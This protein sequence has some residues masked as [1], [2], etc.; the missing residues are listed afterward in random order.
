MKGMSLL[1]MIR[2]PLFLSCLSAFLIIAPTGIS[3]LY[4]QEGKDSL[5]LSRD[6]ILEM[7]Y[8]SLLD[9]PMEEVLRI[10]RVAGLTVDELFNM[11]ISTAGNKK[12][13]VSEVPASVVVLTR[14]DIAN[15]G[16]R[17][18]S[19][20]L[21]HVPGLYPIDNLSFF[22]TSFGVRGFWADQ[23][24][25]NLMIMID[26]VKQTF[27]F[28]GSHPLTKA[29]IPV[30]SIE[31]IEIIRGPMSVI[32]G[33]GAFFGAINIITKPQKEISDCQASLSYGS[34]NTTQTFL[35]I[36]EYKGDAGFMVNAS[37]TISD[38]MDEPLS[39][40]STHNYAPLGYTTTTDRLGESNKF[41]SLN[42][43]WKG[44]NAQ[45]NYMESRKGGFL[46]QP[47]G[48]EGSISELR[49]TS[50]SLE[51]RKKISQWFTA[52]A[53]LRYQHDW[54]NN[55]LDRDW[56][57]R[58][59]DSSLHIIADIYEYDQYENN[60]VEVEAI[61][62]LNPLRALSITAGL[63]YRGVTELN[64][65]N[66]HPI[67]MNPIYYNADWYLENPA[68]IANL[69]PYLQIQYVPVEKLK[70]IGG[71]RLQYSPGFEFAI[72]YAYDTVA[73]KDPYFTNKYLHYSYHPD[74]FELVPRLAAIYS[75]NDEN[76]LK[77]LYGKAMK[78][79]SFE[80]V[81]DASTRGFDVDPEY[82]NTLEINYTSRISS[83]LKFGASAF[84][85]YLD[86]LIVR[87]TLIEYLPNDTNLYSV[88]DNGAN[89][90]SMGAEL[91]FTYTPLR[92][93]NLQAALTYQKTRSRNPDTDSFPVPYSPPLL[94][95]LNLVWNPIS[96][97]N[98]S[99]SATYVDKMI[100][101]WDP[102]KRAKDKTL[103]AYYGV[104]G[105][106]YFNLGC[107]FRWD[108]ILRTPFY[109]NLHVMN[110][111]N[112]TQYYP[113]TNFSSWADKGTL[114][115]MRSFLFTLGIHF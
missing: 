41:F 32:Y 48:R 110:L 12:E 55:D 80:S 73:F 97:M 4:G 89:R 29:S 68:G 45:M 47:S 79:A 7:P 59:K 82:I 115:P 37:W 70:I 113:T 14:E 85:N 52:E 23:E 36:R 18:V 10:A 38:G 27:E 74:R 16:Y 11:R 87:K 102:L 44:F 60:A 31:R 93:L 1:G 103:G 33:S 50:F 95:Y 13:K 106:S 30:E 58:E 6:Q 28:F 9:L 26:G 51:Y 67:F 92:S 57:W 25:S 75:F 42:G 40:M 98:L 86:D 39:K 19:E 72:R 56:A 54:V 64:Y 46:F 81:T 104:P 35:G 53:K 69:A 90:K 65:T 96:S 78:N 101:G 91:T 77:I 3:Q 34:G 107:N 66:D 43:K 22:G 15:N 17:T 83:S 8:D 62:F 109:F 2:K 88:L 20:I 5:R 105:K 100:T 63:S 94:A 61:A 111:L 114:R 99:V 71:L 76:I 49:A 24:N 21:E 112:S 108:P 84:L